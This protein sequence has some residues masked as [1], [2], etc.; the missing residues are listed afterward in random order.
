MI[1][2]KTQK[3][4]PTEERE[5]YALATKRDG[6]ICQRCLRYCGPTNRDHRKPRGQG[7]LT[8]AGNLQ[9][10]GG[11]GTTGCHGWRTENPADALAQGWSVPSFADPLSWP[12]AR[13]F[14]T[15]WNTL[16]LGWVLYDDLGGFREINYLVARRL[17]RGLVNA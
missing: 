2:P 5:A 9:C 10:L 14:P 7:G 16:R 12:A 17:G 6:D 13:W 11:S 15:P 8:T 4:T 1:E 3:P